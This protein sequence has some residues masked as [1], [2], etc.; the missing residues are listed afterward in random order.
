MLSAYCVS[1]TCALFVMWCC[2]DCT[3]A[4]GSGFHHARMN[5]KLLMAIGKSSLF[6]NKRGAQDGAEVF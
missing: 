4:K 3:F 6:L 5:S 2:S 1:F